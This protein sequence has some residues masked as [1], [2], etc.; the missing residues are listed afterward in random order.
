M[1]RL[2]SP[3][4][5]KK[6]L[7]F[8]LPSL[9]VAGTLGGIALMDHFLF[10]NPNIEKQ[11]L[12]K[13]NSYGARLLDMS[14]PWGTLSSDDPA[15]FLMAMLGSADSTLRE[16][17]QQVLG[18]LTPERL[19][20]LARI[21][22]TIEFSEK[23]KA[24][25]ARLLVYVLGSESGAAKLERVFDIMQRLSEAKM[26]K[27]KTANDGEMENQALDQVAKEGLEA[28]ATG[29]GQTAGEKTGVGD[30]LV[31]FLDIEDPAV[32]DELV[33][34]LIQ[35]PE[36][37]YNE[38]MNIV[39]SLPPKYSRQLID[40]VQSLNANQTK[41]VVGLL[42]QMDPPKIP[43]LMDQLFA[44]QTSQLLHVVDVLSEIPSSDLNLLATLISSFSKSDFLALV[45]IAEKTNNTKLAE[46][47][48]VGKRIN[49]SNFASATQMLD[50]FSGQYVNKAIDIMGNLS[51][52]DIN[53]LTNMETRLNNA[54]AKKGIDV[55]YSLRNA[56]TQSDLLK[57]AGY[58][59]RE[60]LGRG[61]Q[62]LDDVKVATVEQVV[63]VSK[64]LSN[65]KSKNQLADQL[66]RIRNPYDYSV[67]G[68]VYSV[69][70]PTA[71]AGVRG[72]PREAGEVV[73]ETTYGV[74]YPYKPPQLVKEPDKKLINR[75]EN[76]V[77]KIVDIN[78]NQL[79]EKLL[80]HS[81][82]LDTRGLVRGADVYIDLELGNDQKRAHR[83]VETYGRT[84]V[85][86][87]TSAIDTLHDIDNKHV[88]A[89]VDIVATSDD[90]L[91]KESIEYSERLKARL[92]N[93]EGLAA[94]SRAINIASR[95]ETNEERQRG[96]DALELER[97]VR[98]R[99]ILKQVD[100]NMEPLVIDAPAIS[101]NILFNHKRIMRITDLYHELRDKYPQASP[102]QRTP[103]IE[104][105]DVLAGAD[106]LT[107]GAKDGAGTSR[108]ITQERKLYRIAQY[109]DETKE[110]LDFRVF[111]ITS[112]PI[113][114][115]HNQ[116]DNFV[117]KRPEAIK[118]K[119]SGVTLIKPESTSGL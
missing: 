41:K 102:S 29:E 119:K 6:F 114:V 99:R 68:T 55:L 43:P 74:A 47:L 33:E 75:V 113:T 77:Q 8:G 36:A 2:A 62:V 84:D 70:S 17:F 76:L 46:L 28:P 53:S 14:N 95:V 69:R 1:Q 34:M 20:K 42:E 57:E 108:F 91:L 97:D 56:S 87:R 117:V 16:K 48:Q 51:N 38:I 40:L 10:Q 44:L 39:V 98:V 82:D 64:G 21:F 9:L 26:A 93:K 18:K 115:L 12:A 23:Q 50:S 79:N 86:Y 7:V 92:G 101:D 73:A 32:F 63:S 103:A 3:M 107:L 112:R 58:L 27:A 96:L 72:K 88:N 61:I 52:A 60:N 81:D 15:A 106:G 30:V 105:A 104:L 31:G 37:L 22:N 45:S 19:E 89:A 25:F 71:V 35:L 67:R 83:L 11:L 90:K 24:R 59:S 13:Q 54:D 65:S 4:F 116:E 110:V 111:Y 80:E 118:D 85:Q 109:L 66:Y 100:G 49:S 94:T 5:R 78:D